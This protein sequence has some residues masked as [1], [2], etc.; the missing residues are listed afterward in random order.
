MKN[1]KKIFASDKNLSFEK[2]AY[3][4]ANGSNLLIIMTEWHEFIQLDLE[5]IKHLMKNPIILDG[6]NI[7]DPSKVRSIGFIYQG[8]GR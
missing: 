2:S 3:E 6:R 5:K 1:A 7:Y 8:V 4:V